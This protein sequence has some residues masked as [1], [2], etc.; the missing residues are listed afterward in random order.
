MTHTDRARALALL[1]AANFLRD[2]HDHLSVQEI[3]TALRHTADEADPMVGSL[4]RDGFGLD[5]I[6]EMLAAPAVSA[7][8][9]PAADQTVPVC[10]CGH[11]MSWHHEDVC[12]LEGCGCN[13]GRE[14]E[15]PT[16]PSRRAGLRDDIAA[17]MREHYLH[18]SREEADADGNMPC[19][20]GDWREPGP[21]GSDEDDW[22]SHLADAVLPVLYREWPWLRAEADQTAPTVLPPPEGPEYTPCGCGHIEPEHREQRP[23]WTR[24]ACLK[25]ACVD[26][27][28]VSSA[29]A[30]WVDGHPQLEA[31]AAAVYER[32]ETGDGGIVHDDPRNIAV[33]ALA[34]V[35]PVCSDPIECSHEAALGEAQQ[36]ARCLGLMVDE[37]GAG[38]SALT[39]KLRRV[40]ELHRE[41]CILAK[42]QVPPTAFTCGMCEVLDAPAAVVLPASTGQTH[43]AP[44]TDAERTMLTYAL[45][46]A[47]EHIW[48]RDGFTDG[49]QAAVTSLRRLAAEPAA[50]EPADETPTPCGPAPD[51]CDAE[52]GEPCDNHERE[53]AHAEG[54]HVFCGPECDQGCT[55]GVAG[56]CF[57]PDGHYADCPH[58]KPAVGRQT[59][60]EN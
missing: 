39:E 32:C 59:K 42:G 58:H 6:A 8:Q 3:G 46:Q 10:V 41:T 50:A 52:A 4:A 47:Q 49:D 5:E 9:A 31:I 40:R 26:Y 7:G 57:V 29:P 23:G 19:R 44:L 30:V 54:E 43:P 35:P 34:A 45:D 17:A 55:C 53:Q 51:Q 28:P 25:C 38:A 60:Q 48:S 12:L 18:T 27:V 1:E 24:E 33:A 20:C 21:M 36:E 22:D 14:P 13:D 16:T 11:L 2:S 37:Y 56:D 15:E